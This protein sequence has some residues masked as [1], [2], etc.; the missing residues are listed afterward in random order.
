[1]NLILA[2][3][4]NKDFTNEVGPCLNTAKSPSDLE[5]V[6]GKALYPRFFEKG[7]IYPDY[8]GGRLPD[9]DDSR[10]DFYLVG[11]QNIWVSIPAE[12]PEAV[13]P[14]AVDV[15]VVGNYRKT[16]YVENVERDYFKAS[17]VYIIDDNVSWEN[18]E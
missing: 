3:F 12:E 8:R 13:F 14:N 10:V 5:K 11:T 9:P 16:K 15:I 7:E 17:C 6:Y 4:D 18:E 2:D 1:M